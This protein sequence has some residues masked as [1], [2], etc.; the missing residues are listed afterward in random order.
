MKTNKTL[1]YGPRCQVA[2]A[3]VAFMLAL[4]LTASQARAATGTLASSS[5]PLLLLMVPLLLALAYAVRSWTP[6]L[7]RRTAVQRPG[8]A[9][10]WARLVRQADQFFDAHGL[11]GRDPAQAWNP[12]Q[13][14]LL[15]RDR[16]ACL[17]RARLWR[18]RQVDAA[19][20]QQLARD[21]AR[22]GA[23]RGILL[24]ARDV[25]TPAA[26]QLARQQRIMLLDPTHMPTQ[27]AP[28]A[29]VPTRSVV[30]AEL[31]AVRTTEAPTPETNVAP[32]LA[33]TLLLRPRRP[34][35]ARVE[36]QPTEPLI[37]QP[38]DAAETEAGHRPLLLDDWR[39]SPARREF[40]PTEPLLDQPERTATEA[41]TG[42]DSG[43]PLLSDWRPAASRP[44]F[45][46]TEPLVDDTER[47]A[48]DAG[49]R[50]PLLGDWKPVR[51]HPEFLPTEPLLDAPEGEVEHAAG[52]TAQPAPLLPDWW[53]V[54]S[55]PESTPAGSSLSSED[56]AQ[57][58][59]QAPASFT[60]AASPV[61]VSGVP[62][63]TE[64]PA[65]SRR[66]FLPTRPLPASGLLAL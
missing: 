42:A 17:V 10:E 50:A 52:E 39:A 14:L 15:H 46:P 63:L 18:A 12:A 53:P 44:E 29:A 55:Q 19:A 45:L 41:E 61:I 36:F 9:T 48:P 25:F 27:A 54:A 2:A 31:E 4:V 23:N 32:E 16:H 30:R 59:P 28:H 49:P 21:V 66:G 26:H 65:S 60:A 7:R 64:R 51:S 40:L 8:A 1:M 5:L 35:H 37:D 56:D 57:T 6:R 20:V 58:P 11:A 22:V 62:L 43:A 24:C 3:Q 38:E 33:P 47:A 34:A 13:D